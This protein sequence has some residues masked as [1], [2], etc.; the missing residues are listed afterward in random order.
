MAA[1]R[2]LASTGEAARKPLHAFV[3]RACD[4]CLELLRLPA[5]DADLCRQHGEGHDRRANGRV[6]AYPGISM[7][8]TQKIASRRSV[9]RF[10]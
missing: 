10:G 3:R 9:A 5:G 6:S 1:A 7:V 4:D 8:A 2:A